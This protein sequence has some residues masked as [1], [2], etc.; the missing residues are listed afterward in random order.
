M[1]LLENGIR[2]IGSSEGETDMFS[3]IDREKLLE[4]YYNDVPFKTMASEL[5]ISYY[6]CRGAIR[7]LGLPR[8][9][10][11]YTKSNVKTDE[12]EIKKLIEAGLTDIE[13]ATK[14]GVDIGI[15]EIIIEMVEYSMGQGE[16]DGNEKRVHW[17]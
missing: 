10:N 14:I 3:D 1:L 16:Q 4:L 13:I 8:R 2:S 15:A 12:G 7:V 6:K 5:G 11:T 17:C 9:I